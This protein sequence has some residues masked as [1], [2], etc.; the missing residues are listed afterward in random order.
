MRRRYSVEVLARL[1]V[2]VLARPAAAVLVR[3]LAGQP[4]AAPRLVLPY[5]EAPRF[6]L[7]ARC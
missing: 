3:L 1:T 6:G 5:H 4:V 7:A 2:E